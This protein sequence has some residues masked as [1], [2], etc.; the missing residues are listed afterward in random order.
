MKPLIEPGTPIAL[1]APSGAFHPEKFQA[2]LDIIRKRGHHSV[3]VPGSSAPYRYM[4]GS[5]EERAKQLTEAFR[6][7]AYG[8]VWAIRGGY[9]LTR[10]L[11]H[12]DYSQFQS[13]PLIGFSDVVAL[14]SALSNKGFPI[15]HGPVVHSLGTTTDR[16]VDHLFRLIEGKSL[17]NMQGETWVPGSAAGPIR[18]GN[19]CMLATLCGTQWQLDARGHVLVLEEV[20]EYPYRIDRMLQQLKSAGVF[21]GAIGFAIGT[22]T[23]CTG[24]T[25]NTEEVRDILLEHLGT[26]GVPVVGDLPIGHGPENQAFQWNTHASLGNASLKLNANL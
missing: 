11:D 1:V 3:T 25:D 7:P 15:V 23:N 22:F 20:G 18:G 19:L 2:G 14:H 9:G 12:L 17:D 10:I 6:N 26:L 21:D 8:A 24:S 13:K 16:S 4:A 5:D